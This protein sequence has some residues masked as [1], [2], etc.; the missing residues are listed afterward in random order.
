M[1]DLQL[2]AQEQMSERKAAEQARCV[3]ATIAPTVR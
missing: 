3:S 2:A 1:G